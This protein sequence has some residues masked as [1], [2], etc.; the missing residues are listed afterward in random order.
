MEK[1]DYTQGKRYAENLK[2]LWVSLIFYLFSS[3]VSFMDHVFHLA[4]SFHLYLSLLII[5]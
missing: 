3:L 5:G 2:T 1:V 4:L